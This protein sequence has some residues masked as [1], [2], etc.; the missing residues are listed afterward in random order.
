MLRWSVSWN[1]E[2]EFSELE[3][4]LLLCSGVDDGEFFDG[5]GFE[6][7]HHELDSNDKEGL[8]LKTMGNGKPS[9]SKY[10]VKLP[11][12]APQIVNVKCSPRR[13]QQPR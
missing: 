9:K 11:E 13:I 3:E 8:V 12:K 4:E 2:D 1:L 6:G 10:E 7:T 5:L